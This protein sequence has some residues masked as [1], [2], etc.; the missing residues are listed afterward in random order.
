MNPNNIELIREA[1]EKFARRDIAAIFGLFD[2]GIE[3]YQTEQ[4]PWGGTYHGVEQVRDFFAKLLH[5][6][7]SRVEPREFVEAGDH[8]VVIAR[9]H[10]KVQFNTKP[11]DLRAVHVWTLRDRKAVRFEVYID[12]PGMLRALQQE[13]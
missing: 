3:F 9:L 13:V 11:F 5:S 10:G 1:Y 2:D 6:I 4:L 8:V 7:D 12:T